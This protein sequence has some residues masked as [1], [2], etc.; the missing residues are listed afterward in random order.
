MGVEKFGQQILGVEELASSAAEAKNKRKG[1]QVLK[2]MTLKEF[3]DDFSTKHLYAADTLPRA[4]AQHVFLP[5]LL[6]CGGFDSALASATL[7]WSSF[8]TRSR[9]HA[10]NFENINCG[11]SGRKRWALWHK[12]DLKT[13]STKE[14]GW[15]KRSSASGAFSSA[16]NLNVSNVNLTAFP[17]WNELEWY[18]V[19][20]EPG[21]CLF[22]P[23]DWAQTVWSVGEGPFISANVMFGSPTSFDRKSCY[24]L[25]E[26]GFKK[27]DFLSTLRDCNYAGTEIHSKV[28]HCVKR[29]RMPTGDESDERFYSVSGFCDARK[30]VLPEH[31]VTTKK[32]VSGLDQWEKPAKTEL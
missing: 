27:T 15:V 19:T 20:V 28:T 12:K 1:I 16:A 32:Y 8:P 3:T 30:H 22:V 25:E 17:G 18:D 26:R 21:D 23:E 7:W 14:M 11:F 9:V 24:R 4:M 31:D 13:I 5:P 2:T 6:N 29:A 10:D